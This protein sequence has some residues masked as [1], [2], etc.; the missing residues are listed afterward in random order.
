MPLLGVV[1]PNPP[2]ISILRA[3]VRLGPVN[4]SMEDE[5]LYGTGSATWQLMDSPLMWVA[6][7]RALYLQAAAILDA[8]PHPLADVIRGKLNDLEQDLDGEAGTTARSV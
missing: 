2:A 8:L 3:E 5:G 7:A 6:A 4:G 1:A